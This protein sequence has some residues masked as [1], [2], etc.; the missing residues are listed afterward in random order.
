MSDS[1]AGGPTGGATPFTPEQL[2]L[3]NELVRAGI[4][5][6]TS[7]TSS[8]AT[9]SD[10]VVPTVPAGGGAALPPPPGERGSVTTGCT[11][12]QYEKKKKKKRRRRAGTTGRP[13]PR[14]GGRLGPHNC[15][16]DRTAE[17][18]PRVAG[19]KESRRTSDEDRTAGSAAGT[20]G[21]PGQ[22]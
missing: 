12:A 22:A 5:A 10:P 14:D 18:S 15:R 11:L 9:P 16:G 19:S 4:A 7:P 21:G 13:V 6:G 1:E 20:A 3:I 2:V 8:G 17:G